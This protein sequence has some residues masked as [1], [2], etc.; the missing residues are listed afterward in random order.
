M[1]CVAQVAVG[2]V[3]CSHCFPAPTVLLEASVDIFGPGW[4][5]PQGSDSSFLSWEGGMWRVGRQESLLS[6]S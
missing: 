4:E 1:S 6:K 5:P 2:Q 3:P